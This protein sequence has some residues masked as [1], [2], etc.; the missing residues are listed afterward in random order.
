MS[1]KN[2]ARAIYARMPEGDLRHRLAAWVYRRMYRPALADCRWQ[3]GVFSVCTREHIEVRSVRAFDPAP[4]V[5]DF[6]DCSLPAGAT[7]MDIGGN[8]G[9]VACYLAKRIGAQGRVISFEPDPANISIFRRNLELNGVANVTLV[10][11]GAWSE[12]GALEFRAGGNYTSSF[13]PTDH[14]ERAPTQYRTVRVPVTTMD[15]V[16]AQIGLERLDLV[17]MDIE[18]SE[19]QALHGARRMLLRLR[20]DVIVETHVVQGRSTEGEVRTAL[21]EAGYADVR[22]HRHDADTS[23]VFARGRHSPV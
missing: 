8:V 2:I 18:G 5:A 20:P 15:A 6:K 22:S 7:V 4:L 1:L 12:E 11:Q 21:S 13:V 23:V 14:I 10:E 19:V 16:A 3:G 17:K 9:A